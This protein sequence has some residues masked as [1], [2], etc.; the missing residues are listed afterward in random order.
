MNYPYSTAPGTIQKVLSKIQSIGQPSKVSKTWMS[1]VGF[2]KSSEHRFIAILKFLNFIEATGVPTERWTK[3]RSQKTGRQELAIAIRE[4]YAELFEIY[5]DAN[6]IERSELMHFF[7]TR[8]KAGALALNH[9]ISTFKNLVSFA[10]FEEVDTQQNKEKEKEDDTIPVTNEK[11]K[12]HEKLNEE[13]SEKVKS[14]PL[15][16]QFHDSKTGVTINLNIQ[17]TVPETT[18]EKVYDKFFESMKKHLLS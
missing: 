3:F 2:T 14:N 6:T 12:S 18:D 5:P 7:T 17:L 4:A 16:K 11:T 9:T 13:D 10:E 1:S 8:T 15:V